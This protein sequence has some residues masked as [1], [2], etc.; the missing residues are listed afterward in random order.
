M[1]ELKWGMGR[2]KKAGDD[3]AFSVLVSSF[4]RSSV[5]GAL[6]FA[7]LLRTEV[8]APFQTG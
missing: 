7:E 1:E 2:N 5:L 4:R 6:E 3:P 8:R